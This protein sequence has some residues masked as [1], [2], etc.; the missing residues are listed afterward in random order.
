MPIFGSGTSSSQSPCSDFLF[1]RA[2][3]SLALNYT[4]LRTLYK[5]YIHYCEHRVISA[6]RPF[7]KA[8]WGCRTPKPCGM[9]G[10]DR[11]IVI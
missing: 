4:V 11:R 8:A 9:G 7:F 6:V 3:M 10:G 1:T 2:F 5:K